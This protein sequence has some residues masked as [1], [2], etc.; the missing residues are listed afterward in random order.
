MATQ[1]SP[2]FPDGAR[3]LPA[4]QAAPAG[5]A[6]ARTVRRGPVCRCGCPETAPA[7]TPYRAVTP[8]GCR[9]RAKGTGMIWRTGAAVML[10]VATA[11]GASEA[12]PAP[13]PEVPPR[14]RSFLDGGGRLLLT[15]VSPIEGAGGGGL[16]PWALVGGSAFRGEDAGRRRPGTC[17]SPGRRCAT[18]R[19]PRPVPAWGR[20]QSRGRAASTAPSRSASEAMRKGRPMRVPLTLPGLLVPQPVLAAGPVLERAVADPTARAACAH[21]SRHHRRSAAP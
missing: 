7:A 18:C 2:A 1:A 6:S 20:S 14:A 17:P 11:A 9:R 19:P 12:T 21:A 15:G 4:D 5:G 10:P 8:A 3:G 16:V 13:M